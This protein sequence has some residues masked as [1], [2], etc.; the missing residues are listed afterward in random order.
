MKHATNEHNYLQ[1][2][3][4]MSILSKKYLAG[5]LLFG[6][7]LYTQHAFG[8]NTDGI[9]SELEE[10]ESGFATA[11]CAIDPQLPLHSVEIAYDDGCW[12]GW[13]YNVQNSGA[14]GGIK[15]SESDLQHR[16]QQEENSLRPV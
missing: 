3:V 6:S 8:A 16:P 1:E 9:V 7:M 10:S 13:G 11:A 2:E 15:E 5:S 4:N 12:D 14:L